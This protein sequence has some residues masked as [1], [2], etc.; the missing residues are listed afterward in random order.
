MNEIKKII[1][2]ESDAL[3]NDT[4]IKLSGISKKYNLYKNKTDR[5]KEA[6]HPI[7]RKYHREFYALKDINLEIKRGEVLGIVGKNGSG[8]STLLK[9]I[10]SVLTPSSG[11]FNVSGK[12]M[13]LLELGAGFNPDFTGMDNIYFYCSLLGYDRRQTDG[14]VGEILAFAELGD[15]IHQPL[16]TY[17][18]GMKARLAFAVSINVDPDVLVLDEVLAVGDEL[19]RRKCFVRMEEF[20]KGGKTIL[21]V[22]HDL[23]SINHLCG[24]AIL[25]DRG[26]IILEGPTKMVTTH[27]QNYMFTKKENTEQF[28]KKIIEVNTNKEFKESL[29]QKSLTDVNVSALNK[30]DNNKQSSDEPHKAIN[31]TLSNNTSESVKQAA[32]YIPNFKPKTTQVVKNYD[33][34][35]SNIEIRS[36]NGQKVNVLVMHEEYIIKYNF[37]FN[38]CEK[39]V[40]FAYTITNEKGL[41]VINCNTRSNP[42]PKIDI[43]DRYLVE[44]RFSCLLM[45]NTY[46]LTIGTGSQAT[47]EAFYQITD[48]LIFKVVSPVK[49]LHGGFVSL[50]Q[51]PTITRL[52][53][54]INIHCP[55]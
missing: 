38:I 52:N 26:E 29:N 2:T 41:Y 50:Y 7:R 9:I 48:A 5:L 15:F 12:V 16:K 43:G 31:I 54:S 10:S 55:F 22:S 19:F 21:F 8:K 47:N 32:A 34:N 35:I 36:L 18:S 28:R 37:D 1:T 27:Y 30:A 25:L 11:M 4:V 45:P 44:W 40:F 24:R 33:V 51:Q 20:F 14:I 13:A 6:L 46:F 23:Q 39:E 17:S 3:K 53:E 42:L 49:L